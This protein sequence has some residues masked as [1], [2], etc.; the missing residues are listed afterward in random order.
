[1][2]SQP[3]PRRS[4]TQRSKQQLTRKLRE[5]V[6]SFKHRVAASASWSRLLDLQT[7]FGSLSHASH[8][9]I[10]RSS[11][12]VGHPGRPAT[13]ATKMPLGHALSRGQVDVPSLSTSKNLK[14]IVSPYASHRRRF[15]LRVTDHCDRTADPTTQPCGKGHRFAVFTGG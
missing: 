7:E 1:M 13:V 10:K 2:C 14:M 8:Q 5:S 12:S 15:R 4:H 11:L 9:S 6:R 3:P